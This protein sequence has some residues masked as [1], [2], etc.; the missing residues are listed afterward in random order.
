[1]LDLD[2]GVNIDSLAGVVIFLTPLGY[3]YSIFEVLDQLRRHF[4]QFVGG[5]WGPT[6]LG[7]DWRVEHSIIYYLTAN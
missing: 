3:I 6:C 4:G 2:I 7:F 5:R 1:M